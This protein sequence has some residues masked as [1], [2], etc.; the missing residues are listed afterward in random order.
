MGRDP[1]PIC[2]VLALPALPAF[3]GATMHQ[4]TILSRDAAKL[5]AQLEALNLPDLALH[6]VVSD[7]QQVDTHGMQLLL[8]EPDLALSLLARSGDLRWLQSTWAGNAPLIRASKR[9]YQLTAAKGIFD[10]RIREYVA[11]YLLHFSR[12]IDGF[13]PGDSGTNNTAT[14]DWQSVPVGQLAGSTLGVLG[15]GSMARALIPMAKAFDMRVLGLNRRGATDTDYDQLFSADQWPAF[16]RECDYVVSLL[17]DTPATRGFIHQAFLNALPDHAVLINAGR[18][19][20]I[21]ESDLLSALDQQRLKA[22]VL[23]VF[24]TEPLPES[25]PYW[26]HPRIWVTHHTAAISEP[27]AVAQVFAQNYKRWHAG[28]PLQYQVN[29]EQGY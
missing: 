27:K 7:P 6:Q 22:A 11:A 29:F 14:S 21:V 2:P 9:D 4:L 23:D 10:A 3:W 18:G 17:P 19:N 5:A 25:H 1:L 8:A 12:N 20:S 28:E 16:A 24:D 26:R 13:H 15:A